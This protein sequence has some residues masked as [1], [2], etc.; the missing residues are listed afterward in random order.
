MLMAFQTFIALALRIFVPTGVPPRLVG[1][2][3]RLDVGFV[4][5]LAVG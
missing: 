2:T 5:D 1:T 3:P 4:N